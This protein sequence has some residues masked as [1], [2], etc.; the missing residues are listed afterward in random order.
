LNNPSDSQLDTYLLWQD[1]N[2]T[3]QMSWSDT[4][5]GW[6]GPIAHPAFAGANNKTALACLTGLTFPDFPLPAGPELSRCYF[7]AGGLLREVSFDGTSWDVIGDV[8]ID[9]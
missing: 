5:A 7:Q 1:S 4:D 8:P 2:N 6:E 3:I 9:F